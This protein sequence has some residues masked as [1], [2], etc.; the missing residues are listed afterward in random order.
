MDIYVM[1]ADGSHVRRITFGTA[2]V[3][4]TWSPDGQR[5]AYTARG[6]DGN[7]QIMAVEL[8]AGRTHDLSRDAA[9][10]DEVWTG[11]WG[12]DGRIVFNRT[13]NPGSDDTGI[14]QENL[15][16]ASL[17]I[18]AVLV[19]VALVLTGGLGLPFG[20]LAAASLIGF[21]LASAPTM[22]WRFLPVGLAVGLAADVLAW[23][24]PADRRAA[25]IGAV[26]AA[27]VVLG[28]GLVI[29]LTGKLA[30]SPTLLYG[31]AAAAAAAGWGLGPL[32]GQPRRQAPTVPA[33]G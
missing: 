28:S 12:P 25:V 18:T 13:T 7:G 31:V 16:A 32:T 11:G 26:T 22:E 19:A 29:L 1:D 30:W 14:I 5:L 20:S 10:A 2:N 24:L 9:F 6:A 8:A 21:A 15:G 17:L 4:P 23:R 33:D 27:L 3:A